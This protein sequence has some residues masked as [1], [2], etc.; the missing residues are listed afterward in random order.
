MRSAKINV[1]AFEKD[2]S[3]R[4]GYLYTLTTR[5]S[6]RMATGRSL[7]AILATG[8]LAGHSV[9]DMGCGDGYYTTRLWDQGRPRAMTGVDA[10]AAAI[11]V[12]CEQ[13]QERPI[14]FE[15]AEVH[16]LP[17]R[18]NSFD[19]A[20]VQSILHHDDDP[21][22]IIREAFRVA[23]VILIHEPN[24]YN[25]GLKIIETTSRYHREHG[26]KSYTPRL[27]RRWIEEAGGEPQW[28]RYAGFVPMFCPDWL[29]RAMKAVEPVVEGLPGIRALGCAVF[30]VVA[31]QK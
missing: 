1:E 16:A 5:L 23:P 28:Q 4:G 13:K 24:G 7:E 31:R 14:R 6:C 11:R 27:I 15:V 29:A 20:L 21:A 26:E 9:I 22:G 3:S 25:F 17:F 12:A 30:V 8:Q 2:A 10:A 18:N 19:V